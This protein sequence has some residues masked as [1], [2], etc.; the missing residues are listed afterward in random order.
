[1]ITFTESA[2]EHLEGALEPTD[3]V[4]VGVIAGGCSGFSYSLTVE[5]ETDRRENDTMVE[6]GGIKVCLDPMS[7]KMLSD[8]VVDYVQTLQSSGFKFDNTKASSTCG[9]G[10]SFSQDR[11]CPK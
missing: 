1:M 9:C 6:L 4:R 8:T 5:E 11:S 10:T 7:D 3:H 2:I